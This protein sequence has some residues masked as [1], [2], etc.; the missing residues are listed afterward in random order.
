MR[1]DSWG[2][3][4][5][6][7]FRGSFAMVA[8]RGLAGMRHSSMRSVVVGVVAARNYQRF[9]A[10][11]WNARRIRPWRGRFITDNRTWLGRAMVLDRYDLMVSFCLDS[12][13]VDVGCSSL[14]GWL[15]SVT[16]L[17]YNVS[18]FELALYEGSVSGWLV[19]GKDGN[20]GS[21]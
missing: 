8:S 12:V 9:G 17:S 6:V 21:C 2:I 10:R 3:D 13:L 16:F 14:D 11:I 5:A 1:E 15:E 7:D 4:R 18:F 19:F 20:P